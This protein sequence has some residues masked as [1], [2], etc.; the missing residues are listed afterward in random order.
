MVFAFY[1]KD[2]CPPWQVARLYD[3]F[4]EQAIDL[5]SNKFLIGITITSGTSDLVA[6]DL[7]SRVR[8]LNRRGGSDPAPNH[9]L[10]LPPLLC[11]LLCHDL[12]ETL[13]LRGK[14]PIVRTHEGRE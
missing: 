12:Y 6:T 5:S 8:W 3:T 11:Q 13:L 10:R 14:H 4:S 1:Y 2:L 7:K 9:P